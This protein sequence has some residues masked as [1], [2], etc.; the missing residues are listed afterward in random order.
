M[1]LYKNMSILPVFQNPI[2][3]DANYTFKVEWMKSA[4]WRSV[5]TL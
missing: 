2:I 3:Y 1:S 4:R 5:G